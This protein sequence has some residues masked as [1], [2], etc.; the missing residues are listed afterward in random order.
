MIDLKRFSKING[1]RLKKSGSD[2][3]TICFDAYGK[4]KEKYD[5]T[6]W[7]GEQLYVIAK[8]EKES[9][10]D[11]KVR[12]MNEFC[13]LCDSDQHEMGSSGKVTVLQG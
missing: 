4:S 1:V 9:D 3:F 11:F 10:D 2:S 8:G 6:P 13:N 5:S 12:A 7:L